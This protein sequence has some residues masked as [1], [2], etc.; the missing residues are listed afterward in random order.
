MSGERPCKCLE[1]LLS[2]YVSPGENG[3]GYFGSTQISYSV[4]LKN[5]VRPTPRRPWVKERT[6]TMKRVEIRGGFCPHCGKKIV[7]VSQRNLSINPTP[8]EA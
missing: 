2:R 3:W 6:H 8:E 5:P 1:K 4:P 7:T